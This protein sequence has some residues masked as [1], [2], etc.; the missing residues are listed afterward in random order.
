VLAT[1]LAADA[2]VGRAIDAVVAIGVDQAGAG[3]VVVG[4][5]V[6]VVIDPVARRVDRGGRRAW[7]ARLHDAGHADRRPPAQPL[8]ALRTDEVLVGATVAVVIVPLADALVRSRQG[9]A[10]HLATIGRVAVAVGPAG[11]AADGAGAE[12]AVRQGMVAGRADMA[13]GAAVR[14]VE[15]DVEVLVGQAVAV[16]IPTVAELGRAT[17]AVAVPG[18]GAAVAVVVGGRGGGARGAG[19]LKNLRRRPK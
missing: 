13:A 15:I 7:G 17:R 19:G 9:D 12:D 16:V 11:L 3:D 8:A 10:G 4:A 5:A 18:V 2:G 1:T 6:A 14:R